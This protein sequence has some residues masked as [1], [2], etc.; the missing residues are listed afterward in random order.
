MDCL[1][2]VDEAQRFHYYPNN[3]YYRGWDNKASF[4]VDLPDGLLRDCVLDAHVE[5]TGEAHA[6]AVYF[7]QDVLVLLLRVPVQDEVGGP[8]ER[9]FSLVQSAFD[10]VHLGEEEVHQILPLLGFVVGVLCA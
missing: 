1:R 7:S 2:S 5:L 8:N 3:I 10:Q 4:G 6:G 9:G